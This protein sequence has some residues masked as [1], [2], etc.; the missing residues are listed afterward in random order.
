VKSGGARRGEVPYFHSDDVTRLLKVLQEATRAT[1]TGES[2]VYIEP[3]GG[4]KAHANY[5]HLIFG[6]RGSGKSTLMRF[7]QREKAEARQVA[8]WIDQE[9]FSGLSYPDVLVSCVET[10]MRD[11]AVAVQRTAE[12]ERAGWA[13][14]KRI[15]PR[16]KSQ[17]DQLLETLRQA[18]AN[19]RT[20]K[21]A[22]RERRVEWTHSA[23]S[24]QTSER[25]G[26]L[27]LGSSDVN[28]L[29]QG[30]RGRAASQ[31]YQVTEVVES[32]KD[33]FLERVL[34]DLRD[35][36]RAASKRCGGGFVFL[37]DVYHLNRDDQ[38]RVL[39]YLHRLVKDTGLWLKI[40]TI[41]YLSTTYTT[42]PAPRGI[43]EGQDAK[44]VALDAGLRRLNISQQFLEK[45]LRGLGEKAQV[46]LDKVF[47]PTSLRRMAFAS[48]CVAR[49]YLEIAAEAIEKAR[50]RPETRKSGFDRVTVEDVNGAARSLA[51]SKI[52]DLEADAPSEAAE[53]RTL[54]GELTAFCQSQ[55]A[56]YF[57]VSSTDRELGRRMDALQHLRF[58]H[59]IDEDETIPDPGSEQ[60]DVWLLDFSQLS[61]TRG[62]KA[63]D[64]DG[65]QKRERRRRRTLVYTGDPDVRRA[66]PP[67]DDED[68][69]FEL[70]DE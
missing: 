58:A 60:F 24:T 21:F 23:S 17:D 66:R 49:D 43:Q 36:V 6:Q 39:G 47:V 32:R 65:W 29:G 16:R 15:V 59:L 31:E 53:L 44:S 22:E 68:T 57:L 67:T 63:M 52:K 35:L 30:K 45:I 37:D 2:E 42:R 4:E 25:I 1:P 27:K 38:P 20:L 54:V 33:E 19:F 10:V 3:P 8:A 18:E 51:P 40:G 55:S 12:H 46:D 9:V 50:N 61:A 56:A 34:P 62:N 5:H 28:L 69:L 64:F 26:T 13:W 11:A 48:G 70:E 7:L 41:R 14:W